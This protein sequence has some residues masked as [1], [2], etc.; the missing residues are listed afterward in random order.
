MTCAK[1]MW[2]R[3]TEHNNGQNMC[4][5]RCEGAGRSTCAPPPTPSPRS[6]SGQ[7]LQKMSKLRLKREVSTRISP[8]NISINSF[9]KLLFMRCVH[10]SLVL[11]S[12]FVGI[13]LNWASVLGSTSSSTKK[14]SFS[15][16]FNTSHVSKLIGQR[17][18]FKTLSAYPSSV[19][20]VRLMW[21]ISVCSLYVKL[22]IRQASTEIML[23]CA[24]SCIMMFGWC[25]L[26][27]SAISV[28]RIN[29]AGIKCLLMMC[30]AAVATIIW[31]NILPHKI[32]LDATP[33]ITKIGSK[34]FMLDPSATDFA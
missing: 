3:S 32:Y 11:S 30:M 10:K 34:N 12:N 21:I 20:G 28:K 29:S 24:K 7:N 25:I 17:L 33:F 22:S 31:R 18:V 2:T 1:W 4:E 14:I 23:L 15:L 8:R 13:S 9:N 27:V 5:A 16:A 26:L 6:E 19:L